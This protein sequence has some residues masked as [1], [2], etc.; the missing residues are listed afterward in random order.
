MFIVRCRPDVNGKPKTLYHLEGL[1]TNKK[2]A[3]KFKTKKEAEK[4]AA[5]HRR[6]GDKTAAVISLQSS[7]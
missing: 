6:H 1:V 4:V 5:L 7:P 2:K 3:L